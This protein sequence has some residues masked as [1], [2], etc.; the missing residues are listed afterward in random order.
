MTWGRMD[1]FN[2]R[3]EALDR[4]LNFVLKANLICLEPKHIVAFQQ[5]DL[6]SSV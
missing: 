3:F 5:T 1:F 6:K 2:F 4:A